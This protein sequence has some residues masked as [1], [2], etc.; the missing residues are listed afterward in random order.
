MAVNMRKFFALSGTIVISVLVII[1]YLFDPFVFIDSDN[2][3]IPRFHDNCPTFRNKSQVDS[4]RDGTGDICDDEHDYDDDDIPDDEDIDDDDDGI[5]DTID[6]MPRSEVIGWDSTNREQDNDKDGLRDVD[7][8]D[9][10]D[11]DRI[12][13]TIDPMP[14]S[15]VIGWDST[16]REKDYDQDGL[17]D[18]DEDD[19]D[20]NDRIPDT[21]D[22]MPRS[23]VIGWDSTNREKDYDQDGLR[24]AD[25]DD[26]DNNDGCIDA[27]AN[28]KIL[29][30]RISPASGQEQIVCNDRFGQMFDTHRQNLQQNHTAIRNEIGFTDDDDKLLTTLLSATA[31][32]RNRRCICNP[33]RHTGCET[34]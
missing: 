7:E 23:K 29:L 28:I 27:C 25:E 17:R 2:D 5:L 9:D 14:R 21:I 24:D 4:D 31:S 26:D 1:L 13:D 16:N 11:N 12:P 19:D 15:K 34:Q 10:D 32:E 6:P 18:V 20:D 33:Q 3:T 22:P 8:D 30:N